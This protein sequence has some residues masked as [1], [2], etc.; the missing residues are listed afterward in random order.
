MLRS[1]H[2]RVT[3]DCKKNLSR[4]SLS[5]RGLLCARFAA[6]D[7]GVKP[8]YIFCHGILV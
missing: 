6:G 1:P 2:G 4:Q 5:K 8:G 3:F 7:G